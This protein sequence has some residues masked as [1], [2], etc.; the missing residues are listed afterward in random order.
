VDKIEKIAWTEDA[1]SSFQDVVKYIAEDSVFYASNF[2][3]KILVLV[4]KLKDF[5]AIGRIVPEYSNPEIREL[6]YQNYRIV[7]KISEKVVYLLLITHCSQE[8][9]SSL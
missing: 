3:K 7:Y 2:A 9:P 6:I 5:P 1:I 4:E 8:L